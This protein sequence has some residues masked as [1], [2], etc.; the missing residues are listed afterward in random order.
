VYQPRGVGL[1]HPRR[2]PST[3]YYTHDSIAQRKCRLLEA[4]SQPGMFEYVEP[5][6]LKSLRATDLCL[7]A[8]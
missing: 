4:A 8:I 3:S 7:T 2:K 1:I 6:P 5:G